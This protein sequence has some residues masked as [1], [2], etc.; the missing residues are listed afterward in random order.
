MSTID[1]GAIIQGGV[2]IGE[3]VGGMLIQDETSEKIK[4]WRKEYPEMDIPQ[5]I[6]AATDLYAREAQRSQVPG[7]DLYAQQIG[8]STARGVGAAREASTSAADLLGA[9]TSLYGQQSQSLTQLEI[10]GARQQAQNRQ[11]YGQQLNRQGMWEQQQYLTNELIPWNVRMNELQ[12]IQQ[13]AY[14]MI[15]GG[16]NTL[17]ASGANFGGG[18]ATYDTPSSSFSGTDTSYA[19]TSYTSN[20]SGQTLGQNMYSGSNPSGQ[21]LGQNMYG[22]SNPAGQTLG[23]SMYG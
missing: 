9:T 4:E 1:I 20:P 13:S 19:N 21:T 12:G 7:Y 10:E 18:G 3:I 22:G 5:S 15:V 17:S 2:G 8:Q 14:D 6:I 23:Q 16:I 11:L